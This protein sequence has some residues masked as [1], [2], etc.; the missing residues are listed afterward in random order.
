[1]SSQFES[2]ILLKDG[3]LVRDR[4][5]T[6]LQNFD[7]RSRSYPIRDVIHGDV[8]QR[9]YTWRCGSHLDQG[10]DGACVG[11]S[12]VHELIARPKVVKGLDGKFAKEHVYWEAQKI[13]PW[14]GGSFPGAD[15]FYEGTSVLAG[16]KILQKLGYIQEYRWCF[17]VEDLVLAIGHLGPAILG[18]PWY[19]SMFDLHACGQLH[20]YGQVVGGHAILCKGVDV[21]NKT[22]TLH[23]SWGESWGDNGDAKISWV[24]MDRLLR[25]G[26]EAVIPLVRKLES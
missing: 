26:G 5:L 13:D 19:E 18:I 20:V 4:R 8:K 17:G 10:F 25:A 14:S 24:E 2:E 6:R 15:P 3:S 21:K 1:M 11:F 16:V 23:N 9:S 7:D 22:L 12:M